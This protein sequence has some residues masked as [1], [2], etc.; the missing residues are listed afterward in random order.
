MVYKIQ[1]LKPS[2]KKQGSVDTSAA[3][4]ALAFDSNSDIIMFSEE[5]WFSIL[6]SWIKSA[7]L[8]LLSALLIFAAL[9]TV[10]AATLFFVTGVDDKPAF[11]ARNTFLGGVPSVEDTILISKNTP[12]STDP[13]FRL[14][15][16]FLGVNEP[17]IVKVLT[18]PT[19]TVSAS[20]GTVT[21][22]GKNPNTFDG[23]FVNDKGETS[24]L[25][26]TLMTDQILVEC[27]SG[28]CTSG[29]FFLVKVDNVYGEVKNVEGVQ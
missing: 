16:A 15:S 18:E 13:L 23:A 9:Y 12:A 28:S 14:Q 6:G 19:D 4:P 1:D 29:Q 20:G 3:K 17:A 24:N 5:S 8:L 26:Q 21:V 10:L 7:L 11:V 27:V 22:T 25:N 2:L